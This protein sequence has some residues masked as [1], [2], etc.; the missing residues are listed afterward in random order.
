MASDT[1]RV[2]AGRSSDQSSLDDTSPT[3]ILHILS[4]SLQAPNRITLNQLPLT[5]KIGELKDHI[6]RTVASQPRPETQRLIYRG[7]PLLNDG[8][9]LQN[10]VEPSEVRPMANTLFNLVAILT[11]LSHH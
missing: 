11:I 5:T 2:E 1:E 8:E 6:Y 9:T 7:K 10:I 3:I 4:P